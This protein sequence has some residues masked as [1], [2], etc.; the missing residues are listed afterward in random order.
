MTS[1]LKQATARRRLLHDD[2]EVDPNRHSVAVLGL[3]ITP[4]RADSSL[5]DLLR[6]AWNS[7][8]SPPVSIRPCAPLSA[9]GIERSPGRFSTP[10]QIPPST[11]TS[12]ANKILPSSGIA[13]LERERRRT[14]TRL[15]AANEHKTALQAL[16]RQCYTRLGRIVPSEGIYESLFDCFN[17][18]SSVRCCPRRLVYKYVRFS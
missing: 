10:V 13:W 14:E 5:R 18:E 11:S 4:P 6:P 12:S 2:D 8:S 9:F 3:T 17:S 1:P 16:L 7:R 15:Q